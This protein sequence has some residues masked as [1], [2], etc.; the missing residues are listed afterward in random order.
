MTCI[1][2]VVR[3]DCV[4]LAADSAFSGS[5]DVDVTLV[6]KVWVVELR[7]G[8]HVGVGT[9]GNPRV[10]QV[11]RWCTPWGDLFGPGPD[12]EAVGWLVQTLIPVM[13]A[14][15]AEHDVPTN[16]GTPGTI[17]ADML[18]A[19]RGRLFAVHAAWQVHEV[20]PFAATGSGFQVALGALH[21]LRRSRCPEPWLAAL[22]ASA[23]FVP[24][25]SPPFVTV[26]VPNDRDS[27]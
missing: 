27:E 8:T 15:F 2:G 10:A 25:V 17:D 4:V 24:G 1:V 5:C 19:V 22:E 9:A 18:L 26:T 3:K 14:I 7:D 12:E 11:A 16:E 13:R 21:A 23:R 20:E 6:P